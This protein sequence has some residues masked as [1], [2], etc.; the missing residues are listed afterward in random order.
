MQECVGFTVPEWML[1]KMKEQMN[2]L[3]SDGQKMSTSLPPLAT[4]RIVAA[5]VSFPVYP[6]LFFMMF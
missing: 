3:R 4:V 2:A 1:V 5:Y 6:P